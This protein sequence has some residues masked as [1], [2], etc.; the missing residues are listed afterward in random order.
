[1]PECRDSFAELRELANMSTRSVLD[2]HR[3]K[4][5]LTEMQ[6]KLAVT[7]VGFLGSF[8]LLGLAAHRHSLAFF[9]ALVAFIVSLHWATQYFGLCRQLHQRCLTSEKGGEESS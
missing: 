5:L 3:V 6:D 7:L 4:Q 9:A 2:T 8:A 1:V